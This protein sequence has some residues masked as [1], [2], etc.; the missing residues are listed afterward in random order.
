MTE[1]DDD[2][3]RGETVLSGDWISRRGCL[4]DRLGGAVIAALFGTRALAASQREAAEKPPGSATNHA[5]K[6]PYDPTDRYEVRTIEGWTVRVN[7]MFVTREPKLAA[8]ALTL[9]RRQLLQIVERVPAASVQKLRTIPIWV[10]EN[11]PHHPCMVYHPDPSWLRQHD[12]NPDK[13]RCVE[14][15]NARHFLKWT[16]EQP[17]MVLHELAHGYHHQYLKTGFDNR[18]VKKAFDKAMN[19]KRYQSVPRTGGTK[20]KAYAATNVQEY[21]AEASEAY[22]GTNDFYPFDRA[23][24]QQYDP[25]MFELLER[26]WRGP[27]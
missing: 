15:S 26:L 21:F 9:L 1:P 14:V 16:Q 5:G 6:V 27:A 7:T 20:E 8:E 22:F 17:W 12:M 19:E 23:E 25:G 13:G 18:E 3:K 11:E 4:L 24:L 2:S 10:E